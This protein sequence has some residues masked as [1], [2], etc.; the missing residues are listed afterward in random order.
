MENQPD[1]VLIDWLTVTSKVD[2]VD[3]F[4][5]LLGMDVHGIAWEEKEAYM[6]GYPMRKTWGGVT[7]LYGARDDMGVCL[8]MS[9]AGCRT[10]ESHSSVSWVELLSVFSSNPADYNITRLDLA[11]DDHSGILDIQRVLDDT[12]DHYYVSNFR[13]WK[14]EYGSEG[15]CIYHGSP[16]SDIRFRIYDKAAERGMSEDT[17]WIRVEAQL[18]KKNAM[19]AVANILRDNDVGSTFAGILRNYLTYR[20]PSDDKNKSRWPIADYWEKLINS[21]AAIRLWS[22][23]GVEY[24]I[25]RLE[26]WLVDQC[27]AAITCWS[28]IYGLDD[29]LEKI[30]NRAVRRS[31]KYQRL[32]DI[33][34]IHNSESLEVKLKNLQL[35]NQRLRLEILGLR[36]K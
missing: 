34:G 11:F 13:W 32:I 15:T 3:T 12:D 26:R 24:N 35:E 20:E 21:V 18:R 1:L 33:V 31:P 25:F 27:G 5:R 8:T 36:Q 22:D 23:P 2:S 19:A 10:F 7:L 4:I 17:H 16:T 28:D 29:L 30:S 9:G 6:N 14:V